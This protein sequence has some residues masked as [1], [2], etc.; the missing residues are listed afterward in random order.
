MA[1][2]KSL[3]REAIKEA[4]RQMQQHPRPLI[5]SKIYSD[6][7]GAGTILEGDTGTDTIE[8]ETWVYF[9]WG[10]IPMGEGR[11]H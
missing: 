3:T 8:D 6:L 11:L 7:M 5:E 9:R 4:V 2:Y 10:I 1:I